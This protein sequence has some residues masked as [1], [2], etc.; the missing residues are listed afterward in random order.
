MQAYFYGGTKLEKRLIAVF[1]ALILCASFMIFRVLDASL[2]S[3]YV[4]TVNSQS[5]YTVTVCSARGTIYDRELRPL[6]GGKSEYR[7]V[8]TPSHETVEYV[9]KVFEPQQLA[10]MEDRLTGTAPFVIKVDDATVDGTGVDVFSAQKRYGSVKTAEH[11]LGYVNMDGN[12]VSGAERVF[13]E[14]LAKNSG[15]LKATYTVDARGRKLSGTQPQVIDSTVL[16]RAGVVLTL[17]ADIQSIAETAALKYLDKGAII[18]TD[19]ESG[20]IL[21]CVSCPRYDPESVAQY[22]SDSDAPL[23]NRAFSCYDVGSVFKLVVA[24][25]ALENGIGDD[26]IYNCTG[27]VEIGNNQFHCSMREGHGEIGIEEAIAYSCNT[28]FINLAQQ[29]GGDRILEFAQK[30]GMAEAVEVCDGWVTDA[31]VLPDSAELQNP[32]ALANLSFGQ[33]RLMLTPLHLS[34]LVGAIANNG[35]AAQPNIFIG[36]NDIEGNIINASQRSEERLLSSENANKLK[37]YMRACVVYGTGK[38]VETSRAV[39]AAK[40]GS[41]QTGI[42]VDGHNIVQA[43]YAGFFP[44]EEPRYACVVLAEDGESG[45]ATA[46]PVFAYIADELSL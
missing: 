11:I 14:V 13:D 38:N 44:Y 3:E 10:Q 22:L 45:A 35:V 4:S 33:G 9:S 23:I 28:Y 31:G 27:C 17:D 2:K 18:I 36:Y 43:W 46:G 8:I 29:L 21:A 41:A 19:I 12:G 26:F 16:S 15:Y 7:A 20:D 39:C 42:K 30:A 40:T 25:A 34:K 5:R 32:A 37:Q 6:A 1:G 24:G